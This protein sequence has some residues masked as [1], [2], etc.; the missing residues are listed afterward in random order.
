MLNKYNII[1]MERLIGIE[2]I[3]SEWKSDTLPLSYSRR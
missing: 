1:K 3:L 2:P